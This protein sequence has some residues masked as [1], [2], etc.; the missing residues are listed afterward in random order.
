MRASRFIRLLPGVAFIGALLAALEIAVATGMASATLT[1]PPSRIAAQV[2]ELVESGKVLIPCSTHWL[3]WRPD[4]PSR[5]GANRARHSYG[6]LPMA[7][8]SPGAFGRSV[9]RFQSR[10]CCLPLMLL[11]GFGSAMK[12][13]IVALGATFPILINALQ[14]TR[15]VDSVLVNT[16]RTLGY[17][18]ANILW[19]VVLP[20]T[21]PMVLAGMKVSLGLSLV[22]VNLAEML[23]AREAWAPSLSTCRDRFVLPR[24]M[25]GW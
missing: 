5:V 4:T 16:A 13:S 1:P 21:A 9:G 15:G 18:S 3:Y 6:A 19:R 24:C 23:S 7:L 2:V 25:R 11:L 17:G 20:S 14:A 22:L 8:Q 12:V 10:H